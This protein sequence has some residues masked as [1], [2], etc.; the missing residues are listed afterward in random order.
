[1]AEFQV[2]TEELTE[3]TNLVTGA[4]LSF[5][6]PGVPDASGYTLRQIRA[7][8]LFSGSG[9][10]VGI[11][12]KI[13]RSD[14]AHSALYAS[15]N[16]NHDT[17]YA[18]ITHDHDG[19][20]AAVAHN[21]DGQ[22]ATLTHNVGHVK[23][24]VDEID[25]DTL[26]IDYIPA[27]YLRSTAPPQVDDPF[28]LT[29][30]LAGIDDALLGAGGGS[31]KIIANVTALQSDSSQSGLAYVQGYSALADGG[32]GTFEPRESGNTVDNG[33]IFPHPSAGNWRWER[34]IV[35]PT[36]AD[37]QQWGADGSGA[38]DSTAAIQNA[39]N[40]ADTIIFPH[41]RFKI[42]STIDIP[43]YRALMGDPR[44]NVNNIIVEGDNAGGKVIGAL[45]A[46][47]AAYED[48]DRT[49]IRIQNIKFEG[50]ADYGLYFPRNT[51]LRL[52]LLRFAFGNNAGVSYLVNDCIHIG[53]P[54]G[55]I[56][57]DIR[58]YTDGNTTPAR[59]VI[60]LDG[61]ANS[62]SIDILYTT[63]TAT[64]GLMV[65][66]QLSTGLGGGRP[67]SQTINN[68]TLQRHVVGICLERASSV[69]VN[70]L[71]TEN[72]QVPIRL[73]ND[74]LSRSAKSCT[75]NSPYMAKMDASAYAGLV[76][77]TG[78][79][80]ALF[81]EGC[82]FNSPLFEDIRSTAVPFHYALYMKRCRGLLLNL[83]AQKGESGSPY[84]GAGP[85]QDY[86][87][88][89]PGADVDNK[90]AVMC[91]D[92]RTDEMIF[93]EHGVNNNKHWITRIVNG[94]PQQ[95]EITFTT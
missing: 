37:V 33:N 47:N 34:A 27:N 5:A 23:G 31:V 52:E 24:G 78:A 20:Y 32:Q 3:E 45:F 28:H 29:A 62:F 16:H 7:E 63:S 86:I 1:M 14:H 40:N 67:L 91:S 51:L 56:L 64:Y 69:I 13:A 41:G 38:T 48:A 39:V 71:Y 70:G 8:N 50:K 85:I 25:A 9:G 35:G 94:M 89:A 18:S 79:V 54:W 72:T 36:Y 53:R 61:D 80:E 6:R 15:V 59:S 87:K 84:R 21:H 75:F 58:A 26:D 95:E 74:A 65:T 10:D 46:G 30:H 66:D 82:T 12:F 83:P 55:T 88:L 4:R 76:N 11:S 49:E 60:W 57:R 73:G 19:V 68:I 81:A 92:T 90:V 44:G 43:A 77:T 42:A 2:A 22:Y 93:P 17:Q